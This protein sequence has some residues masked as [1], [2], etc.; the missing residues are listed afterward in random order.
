MSRLARKLRVGAMRLRP[1]AWL[2]PALFGGLLLVPPATAEPRGGPSRGQHAERADDG[3]SGWRERRE[4]RRDE[5]DEM[6]ERW[7]QMSPDE[8]QQMQEQ[9]RRMRQMSPEER[10]RLCRDIIEANRGLY[11]RRR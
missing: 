3:R 10:Q 2:L 8:R 11:E 1:L 4:A 9:R 7:Q 5:R 6:R